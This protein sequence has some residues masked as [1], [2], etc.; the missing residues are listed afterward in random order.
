M[1]SPTT[2]TKTM[3]MIPTT[4]IKAAMA[5]AKAR[6]ATLVAARPIA[7]AASSVCSATFALGSTVSA[8]AVLTA[9]PAKA[10]SAIFALV[11]TA[12]DALGHSVP[13]ARAQTVS[14]A[15]RASAVLRLA[16][17]FN[18]QLALTPIRVTKRMKTRTKTRKMRTRSVGSSRNQ[19][20]PMKV[21]I[22][23]TALQEEVAPPR[24]LLA[25]LHDLVAALL[26]P[27]LVALHDL[28]VDPTQR[29]RPRRP[30]LPKPLR[31]LPTSPTQ[32]PTKTHAMTAARWLHVSTC[33]RL[34]IYSARHTTA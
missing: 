25:V 3:T 29:R 7:A 11:Q 4:M 26:R 21:L 8:A 13:L 19:G 24:P 23:T 20:P 6:I 10:H 12:L 17:N 18:A 27:L 9:Y 30:F 32:A 5:S 16:T 28:V 22:R 15:L 2:K 1:I 33:L 31:R 14:P 34:L